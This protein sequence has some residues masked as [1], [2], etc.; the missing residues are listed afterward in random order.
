M[1]E[2]ALLLQRELLGHR[3]RHLVDRGIAM[4]LPD[5]RE[6]LDIKDHHRLPV[7]RTAGSMLLSAAWGCPRSHVSNGVLKRQ[8]VLA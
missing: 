4:T 7:G 3:E 2:H 6:L 1:L 8:K 5:R